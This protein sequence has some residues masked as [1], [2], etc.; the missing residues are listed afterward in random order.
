MS[1]SKKITLV[2]S[3]G[4]VFEV[5]EAVVMEAAAIKRMIEDDCADGKI[6][7]PNVKSKTLSKILEYCMKHAE[8]K[9]AAG[10]L[11]SF[12]SDFMKVDT[13]TLYDLLMAANYLEIKKLLGLCC[14][15]VTD[16]IK[17]K[18]PEQI[19]ETFNIKNDFSAEEEDEIRNQNKWA[20]E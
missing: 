19:R 14:Q 2:S 3:D 5:E 20:F 7:L 11:K 16:M 1:S 4:E 8:D 6:P 18:T 17:G 15:T 9:D 12:D 13:N 10:N